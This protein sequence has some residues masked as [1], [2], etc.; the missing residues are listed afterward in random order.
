MILSMY[1]QCDA[2]NTNITHN[3]VRK[4]DILTCSLKPES[5]KHMPSSS[6]CISILPKLSRS[7]FHFAVL[8]TSR[9]FVAKTSR[10][11]SVIYL[12]R[13]SPGCGIKQLWAKP[14]RISQ[15]A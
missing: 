1:V 7:F 5:L 9:A 11:I 14:R 3:I 12:Y 13:D 15:R 8:V 10:F 2:H 4:H 6:Y